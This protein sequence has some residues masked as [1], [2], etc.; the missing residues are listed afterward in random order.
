MEETAI[1]GH[2]T[3]KQSRPMS[4]RA[5]G[6]SKGLCCRD[7]SLSSSEGTSRG[8]FAAITPTTQTRITRTM[9]FALVN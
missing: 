8:N 7:E 1:Q 2:A 6:C 3:F 9:A 4:R 5:S